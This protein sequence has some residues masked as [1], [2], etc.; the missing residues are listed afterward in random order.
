MV[1]TLQKSA[2]L[3]FYASSK[4]LAA[5]AFTPENLDLGD[6]AF[7][8]HV[9]TGLSAAIR[10]P[11][12][13]DNRATVLAAVEVVDSHDPAA[14]R[15]VQRPLTLYGP[16]DVTGI[17]A[18][19]IIRRHPA[20]ATTDAEQG[21][22]A[23]VEFARPD[24]P[25]LFSPF[26][27]QGDRCDPWLALVVV[28]ASVSHLEPSQNERPARLWTKKGQLQPLADNWRFCHA[29]VVGMAV[30]P[31]GPRLHGAGAETVETRLSDGHAAAN[32]SRLLCPRRLDDGVTYVAALVP[33]LDCGVA[34]GLGL[35]GG[36]LAPAWTRAPGD[37]QDDIVLPVYDHWQF[38]TAAGGTFK[39]LATR[40]KPI[41]AP[42]AVGRR[43]IDLSRPGS[44]IPELA[45]D[46]PAGVQVLTCALYSP[47]SLPADQPQRAPWP[48]AQRE[49]LRLRVDQANAP[50]DNLPRIGAR[51]YAR[52]QRAATRLGPVFGAAPFGPHAGDAAD[53][54][55]FTQ[56]NTDPLLR[57]VAQLGA[58]VV[59]KDQEPLMQ[60]AWAQVDG[61]R[62][63][64]QA[65]LWAGL[66]EVVNVSV[67]DRHLAVLDP[68]TLM[69]VTRNVHARIRDG[70]QPR[71]LRAAV[72]ESRTATAC[73]TLAFRRALR[74]GGPM[75]ARVAALAT[76]KLDAGA[77]LAG[78]QGFADHRLAIGTPDGIT[79]L[80]KAGLAFFT[81]AALEKVMKLPANRA[82]SV[83]NRQIAVLTES[84]GALR[85]LSIQR[86]QG[87][88]AGRG[89][90]VLGRDLID[91]VT[92]KLDRLD[93][94]RDRPAGLAERLGEVLVGLNASGGG[95]AAAS[96]AQ[97]DRV[98]AL[99]LQ[100]DAPRG[101]T[102]P[103]PSVTVTGPFNPGRVL[104]REVPQTFGP[105]TFGPQT[106]RR[107]GVVLPQRPGPGRGRGP[108]VV[109]LPTDRPVEPPV[110]NDPLLRFDTPLSRKLRAGIEAL[111]ALPL[112]TL[113]DQLAQMLRDF[114]APP[115]MQTDLGPL[116]VGKAAILSQIDPRVTARAALKGRL[117]LAPGA[118]RPD[119]LDSVGLKPIM[120]APIFNRA[121]SAAL[122]DY[123]RDWL[124]PGLGTLAER[125][126]VTVLSINPAFAEA[127][128]IG[129][130]DEMG[131]E[132]LWRN[133]PTDQRG[134]YFRR[135]WD[136]DQDELSP[137]IHRF[138]KTP[139]G[140]HFQIGGPPAQTGQAKGAL[141]LVVR[142][143]LLRRFPDTV[144]MAVQSIPGSD[145]VTL[146]TSAAPILFHTH[147]KP[148]Y[149]VVGFGLSVEQINAD[150]NWWFVLAQNPTAPRFGAGQRHTPETDRNNID[151]VDFGNVPPGGFLS[152][153]K[154]FDVFDKDSSPNTV[155]WPGHAGIVARVLLSNPV[156]AI[157][158]ARDLIASAK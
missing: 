2:G 155:R 68:G 69:Q 137:L 12:G 16:G 143:E 56:I 35:A 59:Q 34:A 102:G 87:P 82:R 17:D 151:W 108:V 94:L 40:I 5:L 7:V 53:A 39:D 157:F 46:D 80:S 141:A 29:Q 24:F 129:A 131:R 72:I 75:A 134:T 145:P 32:L 133:Y 126:F 31:G 42:W 6:Y 142:G 158:D 14:K 15:S 113:R 70:G 25:W 146:S 50:N 98:K 140:S 19:Q 11:P 88:D 150:G 55:W 135:F 28:E 101:T 109:D 67:R 97:I 64:N 66:A 110:A 119:W 37:E 120:A 79:G 83:L 44:D 8:P 76:G 73:T 90:E 74:P 63:A 122:E 106:F 43:M 100:A 60:A 124:V 26:P 38:R 3:S 30:D 114:A 33:A 115:K 148:D 89:G 118:I 104:R 117:T 154:G 4:A 41:K 54:D 99:S 77:M 57:I 47:A 48:I 71:T 52:Y 116:T 121:M 130:S 105:Q 49:A 95:L 92:D 136:A 36:T 21:F 153:A 1:E 93:A 112:P 125:D 127:F 152:T 58:R 9:R 123:D 91:R 18:G 10:N 86:W 128:L 13:P 103:S 107:G 51:L 84:G 81:D 139:V 132:L 27:A 23:H 149:T 62:K 156:R 61:V 147:L 144:I 111:N 22:L 138:G 78:P 65:I 85:Q 20:P 45:A 96:G